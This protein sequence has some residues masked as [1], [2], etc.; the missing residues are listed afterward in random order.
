MY[1][2]I[3]KLIEEL[4]ELQQALGKL[5]SVDIDEDERDALMNSVID[6]A[7]D[8]RA[9]LSYFEMVNEVERDRKREKDKIKKFHRL[10]LRGF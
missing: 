4:G 3:F 6:E 9:A 8:V 10:G 7:A 5:G 2:G 1:E